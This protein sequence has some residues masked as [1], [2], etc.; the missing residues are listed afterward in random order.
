MTNLN[1]IRRLLLIKA[2]AAKLVPIPKEQ[3][4]PE[5]QAAINRLAIEAIMIIGRLNHV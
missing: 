1:D 4:T 2:E 5:Q 3:R